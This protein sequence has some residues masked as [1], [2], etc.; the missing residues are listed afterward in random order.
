[1]ALMHCTF[2]S[3]VLNVTT[4]MNVILPQDRPYLPVQPRNPAAGEKHPVLFLL[5]GMTDNHSAWLRNTSIERYAEAKGLAVVMPEVDLSFYT[6]MAYGRKYWTFIS[7]ELPVLAR[8]FFPLSEERSETFVAGLSMGGYGAFKLA[9]RCPDMFAAGASL[10]GALNMADVRTRRTDADA[11]QLFDLIFGQEPFHGTDNDLLHVAKEL[12]AAPGLK[13][14][15]YQCCG[16][17][18]FL[19]DDNLVFRNTAAEAGLDLTYVEGPGT[20]EWGY[21]DV[22]IEKILQWLPLELLAKPQP[23]AD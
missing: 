11:N 20:H 17:E 1:M 13:P 16:T 15:L 7:E 21:W 23:D 3:E 8:T 18:D 10:S 12:G 14:A 22:H 9:L 19:Y 5:H 2:F 4:A 6:D